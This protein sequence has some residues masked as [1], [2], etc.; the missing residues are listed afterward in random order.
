MMPV[1]KLA[2]QHWIIIMDMSQLRLM[3]NLKDYHF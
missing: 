3:G 1:A 2:S